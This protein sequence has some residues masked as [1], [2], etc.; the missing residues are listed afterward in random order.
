[1][2]RFPSLA[3][4]ALCAAAL[5]ASAAG[6]ADGTYA[7]VVQWAAPSPW[8]HLAFRV[9]GA[10]GTVYLGAREPALNVTRIG[11]V[12]DLR[13][14]GRA[15]IGDFAGTV[16]ED[17]G[18]GTIAGTFKQG[19]LAAP[20][21]ALRIADV[22]PSTVAARDGAY[23]IGPNRYLLIAVSSEAGG[24]PQFYDSG[25]RRTGVLAPVSPTEAVSGPTIGALLP[26]AERFAFA[27]EP[28]GGVTLRSGNDAPLAGTRTDPYD[29]KDVTFRNGDT[30]LRGTLM[31]PRT[32]G[33]HPAIVL[34][35]GAGPARRPAGLYAIAFLHLGYAVLAFDKRGAGESTGD[36]RTASF[37]DLAGDVIAGIDTIKR[38]PAIDPHRIGLFASS[39]G[40]WVAPI[41]ATRSRDVA[42]V[43]CRV[44]SMV[45]VGENNAWETEGRARDLGV[46][47]ADVGRAVA[48]REQFTRAVIANAGW[49]EL[50]ATADAAKDA[51]WF[52]AFGIPVARLAPDPALAAQLAFDPAPY[53]K[54]VT[55]PALFLFADHDRAVKTAV[56]EPRA[57][58][59]LR[60]AGNRDVTVVVLQRSDHAFLESDT[61]LDQE[62]QRATR[63][64]AG[65]PE[66]LESWSRAHHLGGR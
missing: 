55:V 54:R 40:G 36:Y 35:H 22:S 46:P 14:S 13:F 7:V 23:R 18:F 62:T 58:A 65:L 30:T 1:M 52:P 43:I 64:A 12:V 51:D 3:A 27:P 10:G 21:Q 20:F 11:D 5:P 47:E 38:N 33:P 29:S 31:I 45:T 25:T 61:G 8:Q 48:L 53:W 28:G 6:S 49:D 44:C 57:R 26:I 24:A 17:H 16:G 60:E 41:V 63:M 39:N 34:I 66:A 4:A 32:A 2:K 42:F 56:S 9:Q 59:Y 19:S 15:G 37:P 50:R